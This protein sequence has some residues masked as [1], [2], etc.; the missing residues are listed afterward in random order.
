M[1]P[2]FISPVVWNIT[3][4]PSALCVGSVVTFALWGTDTVGGAGAF[5]LTGN[6]SRVY[7]TRN[8]KTSPTVYSPILD[9]NLANND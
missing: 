2:V 3:G 6:S 5:N 7:D 8:P 4:S 1:F 9:L